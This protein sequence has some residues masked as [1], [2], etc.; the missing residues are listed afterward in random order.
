MPECDE[1]P[2]CLGLVAP[3][4]PGLVPISASVPTDIL[5]LVMLQDLYTKDFNISKKLLPLRY[6]LNVMTIENLE[7]EERIVAYASSDAL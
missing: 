6:Q 7:Q 2:R 5:N 1:P 3:A 4:G